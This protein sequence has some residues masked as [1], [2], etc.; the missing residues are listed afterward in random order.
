MS[1][2]PVSLTWLLIPGGILAPLGI[3]W[4]TPFR[5]EPGTDPLL[6]AR[7]R[8]RLT[9][10]TAALLAA[11]TAGYI[12]FGAFVGSPA[13]LPIALLGWYCWFLMWTRIAIPAIH[14]KNPRRGKALGWSDTPHPSF[15]AVERIAKGPRT[16]PQYLHWLA[17]AIFSGVAFYTLAIRGFLPFAKDDFG[18][19]EE[20]IWIAMLVAFGVIAAVNVVATTIAIRRQAM[21]LAALDARRSLKSKGRFWLLNVAIP[22]LAWAMIFT[23]VWWP[24]DVDAILRVGAIG[25]G[26]IGAGAAVFA[27]LWSY[28]SACGASG[29]QPG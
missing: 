20:R 8:F 29:E 23:A 27:G 14:A 4:L 26:V 15:F 9:V 13:R 10:A 19:T 18:R 28:R 3:T 24:G 7:L 11:L 22:A 16:T 25:A 1:D 2:P 5:S 21:Q 12:F 17:P 6:A